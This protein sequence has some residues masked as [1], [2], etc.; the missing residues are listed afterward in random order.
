MSQS[1][2]RLR[3]ASPL[4]DMDAITRTHESWEE[5]LDARARHPWLRR[6][7]YA[8]CTRKI[9]R[10]A[11]MFRVRKGCAALRAAERRAAVAGALN[12]RTLGS[13]GGVSG[14][15]SGSEIAQPH[16]SRR[17]L[18]AC[19]V[20]RGFA[21]CVPDMR[22]RQRGREIAVHLAR[23]RGKAVLRAELALDGGVLAPQL[24]ALLALLRQDEQARAH[25]QRQ[26]AAIR[27]EGARAAEAEARARHAV[28]MAQ[29]LNPDW[30][31]LPRRDD[32][33]SPVHASYL[34]TRTGRR[35]AGH[36]NASTAAKAARDAAAAV[37]A[38]AE[39]RVR[40]GAAHA[41]EA[42]ASLRRQQAEVANALFRVRLLACAEE[43]GDASAPAPRW[44]RSGESPPL[45]APLSPLGSPLLSP[46]RSA[47]SAGA[48]AVAGGT[49]CRIASSGGWGGSAARSD[50]YRYSAGGAGAAAEYLTGGGARS[51][52]AVDR[53]RSSIRRQAAALMARSMEWTPGPW[54]FIA[55]AAGEAFPVGVAA[56]P[57]LG[58]GSGRGGLTLE[59]LAQA[60]MRGAGGSSSPARS[61]KGSGGVGAAARVAPSRTA[62]ARAT[63]RESPRVGAGASGVGVGGGS[64]RHGQ[65]AGGG[66]ARPNV[67]QSTGATA[68]RTAYSDPLHVHSVPGQAPGQ[69]AREVPPPAGG[70]TT[71]AGPKSPLVPRLR[72][73]S[74]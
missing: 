43:A 71:N 40:E 22:A 38:Q 24:E 72:L 10:C 39:A 47:A 59:A 7:A 27:A 29:H 2:V 30:L 45:H 46:G 34:N 48:G 68:A 19:A 54:D 3:L 35:M 65:G 55:S 15:G 37:L 6:L 53:L 58:G 70:G 21:L 56:V 44:G 52:G 1:M 5:A 4:G 66:S 60:S 18:W 41:A 12:S 13:V 50:S 69:P 26:E 23:R 57:G 8:V 64:F 61:G 67:S 49:S 16:G 31:A 63:P 73:N 25:A 9:V 11:R 36:P 32:P 33:A 74:L 17:L 28:V 14:P 62:A 42:Q 51:P 20:L